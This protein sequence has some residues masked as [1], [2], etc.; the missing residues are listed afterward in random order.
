M[1]EIVDNSTNGTYINDVKVD[2][3]AIMKEGDK[4][5]FG[6]LRGFLIKPGEIAPQTESEF[7]FLVSAFLSF[8]I[9]FC[10]SVGRIYQYYHSYYCINFPARLSFWDLQLSYLRIHIFKGCVRYIFASLFCVSKGGYF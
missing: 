1:F 7:I 4:I 2:N 10:S 6:H 8:I 3:S 5:A 9:T